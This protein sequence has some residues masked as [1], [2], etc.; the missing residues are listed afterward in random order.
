MMSREELVG[1][2]A[3]SMLIA[4]GFLRPQAEDM[5]KFHHQHYRIILNQAEAALDALL[6]SLYVNPD[7]I[8]TNNNDRFTFSYQEQKDYAEYYQQLLEMRK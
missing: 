2:M 3:L 5:Q 8:I 6:N 4:E 1:R 7:P